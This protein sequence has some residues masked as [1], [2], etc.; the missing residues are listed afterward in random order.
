MSAIGK[1]LYRPLV[2]VNRLI[3][4]TSQNDPHQPVDAL[5]SSHSTFEFRRSLGGAR[6]TAQVRTLDY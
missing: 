6:S 5:K 3:D 4:H 2:A 1:R